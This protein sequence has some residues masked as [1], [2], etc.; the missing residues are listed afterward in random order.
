MTK[1]KVKVKEQVRNQNSIMNILINLKLNGFKHTGQLCTSMLRCLNHKYYAVYVKTL[2]CIFDSR[3][4]RYEG[5]RGGARAGAEKGQGSEG[6]HVLFLISN[7]SI[8]SSLIVDSLNS[9]IVAACQNRSAAPPDL[10]F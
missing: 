10:L 1:M 7:N 9:L 4:I 3:P 8:W 5:E 6:A 2:V